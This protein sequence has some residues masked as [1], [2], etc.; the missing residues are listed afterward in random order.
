MLRSGSRGDEVEALQRK[1][2]AMGVNPGTADGV[3]G[4]KTEG[5]VRRFQEREALDVDGIAGPKTLAALGLADDGGSGKDPDGG[6]R[7][8]SV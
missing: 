4:P 1:L 8:E 2:L 7:Q 6:E 5:A 3:F